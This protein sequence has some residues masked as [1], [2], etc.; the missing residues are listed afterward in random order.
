MQQY[1]ETPLIKFVF[2][3]LLEASCYLHSRTYQLYIYATRKR[4]LR[5]LRT[6][7]LWH[8]CE[9]P[10]STSSALASSRQYKELSVLRRLKGEESFFLTGGLATPTDGRHRVLADFCLF[11]LVLQLKNESFFE[12]FLVLSV[13][14]STSMPKQIME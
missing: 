5:I 10:V 9:G 1:S 8:K 14:S 11:L 6:L 3:K 7:P 12:I 2:H 13:L 4:D